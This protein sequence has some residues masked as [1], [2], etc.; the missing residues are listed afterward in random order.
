M[1]QGTKGQGNRPKPATGVK[2]IRGGLD[3]ADHVV[4]LHLAERAPPFSL[5]VPEGQATKF[6]ALHEHHFALGGRRAAYIF[7]DGS[8][9]WVCH[10]STMGRPAAPGSPDFVKHS[11]TLGVA[12]SEASGLRVSSEGREG[13]EEENLPSPTLRP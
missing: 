8:W 7:S 1:V 2:L 4:Q 5:L 10:P 3:H 9:G 12:G 11:T 13:I 6:L